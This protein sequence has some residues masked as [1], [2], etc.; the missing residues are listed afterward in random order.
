MTF[1]LVLEG[2]GRSSAPVGITLISGHCRC[3]TVNADLPF[4]AP[5]A[6]S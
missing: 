4:E 1:G 5:S 3:V 2:S 6:I